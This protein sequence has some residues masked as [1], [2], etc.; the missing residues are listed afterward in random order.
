M[1]NNYMIS[2]TERDIVHFGKGHDD[3]P[4]GR[5]SGRFA[6][7]SGKRPGQHL[8]RKEKKAIKKLK[9]KDEILKGVSA[10]D[11]L[12]IQGDLSVD[13]LNNMVRRIELNQKLM[14]YANAGKTDEWEKVKKIMDKTADVVNWTST[15]IKAWNNVV[16]VY[17]S[18][19]DET[20][21]KLP[22]IKIGGS[23]K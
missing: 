10:S 1:E 20:T 23:S 9:T 11:A 4:P 6:F 12:R 22:P 19:S 17:N 21:K 7:G 13:E 2:S 5:G 16:S 8:S 14:S 15:G 3:N 18:L